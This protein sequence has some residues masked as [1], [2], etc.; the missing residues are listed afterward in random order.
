MKVLHI[1]C[2]YIG[3]TLHQIMVDKLENLGIKNNVFVPTYDRNTSVIVPNNNVC[4]S[5]CFKKWNRIS[6]FYKQ[7]KIINAIK[8]EYNIQDFDIIHAYT[9]FTDGNAA[10]SLSKKYGVV[11]VR[12]TDLNAFFKY[13]PYLRNRGIDILFDAR[14]VFFLSNAYKKQLFE[15]YI[16]RDMQQIINNKS[17]IIPNG[18]DEFWIKNKPDKS[19]IKEINS[20]K[21]KLIYAGK[22]DKNKNIPTVQE[23]VN[24]LNDE[25][26]DVSLTVV[27]K[28]VDKKIFSKINNNQYTRY[29]PAQTKENL[30]STYRQH[31]IFVMPSFTESF[32]LVYAEAMSQGLPVIYSKGQGFD[33]QFEEGLAGYSVDAYSSVS[34]KDK[35]EKLINKKI[36]SENIIKLS[37]K[38]NWNDITVRYSDIYKKILR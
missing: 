24:L 38:F 37:E 33:G 23:A 19:Q 21:V 25:G 5:E 32:G 27:G 13:R 28:V 17:Y 20:K 3:T 15:K 36:N 16:P 26:Y 14:A 11:A 12:N 34:V 10:R 31:D 30:L 2:N 9:L 29:I 4:I 35:I 22:I 1:N 8:K 18:I 7:Y 6:F